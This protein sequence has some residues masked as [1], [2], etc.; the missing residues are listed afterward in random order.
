MGLWSWFF[1]S[2][3]DRVRKAGVYASKQ[4]WAQAR[5]ELMGLEEPEAVALMER[6]E[7]EL[8]K[9][10]L[11]EAVAWGNA[12]DEIRV[13][14]H[15]ELA[16]RF[17]HGQLGEEL[18]QVRRT[19]RELRAERKSEEQRKLEEKQRQLV[20]YAPPEGFPQGPRALDGLLPDDLDPDVADEVAARLGL[21]VEAYPPHLRDQLGALGPVFAQ[22]ILEMD[23]GR[24]EDAYPLLLSLPDTAPLVWWERARAAAA[25][26]HPKD[27]GNAL[28]EFARHAGGHMRIG[29]AHTGVLLAQY[30]AESGEVRTAIRVLRAIAAEGGE[31]GDFFLAQ[32]LEADN[33]LAEADQILTRLA[34]KYPKQ[35]EIHKVLAR[36]RVRGGERRA[37]ILAL[38]AANAQTCDTPG[39][40][41]YTPPDP[42]VLLT[43]ATLYLEEG[44]V[45]RGLELAG[46]LPPSG[47]QTW[48]A[49]YLGALVARAEGRPDAEEI[50]ASVRA[51]TPQVGPQA[52]RL[53]TFLPTGA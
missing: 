39:K 32:L 51:Q 31:E 14:M 29:N 5:D 33:E 34:R 26:G 35:R 2:P 43:L 7:L 37:A 4:K 20:D 8:A 19:L 11:A 16:E 6:V 27:A 40:C 23:E 53:A 30:H 42:E 49:A 47:A 3:A 22:A 24:P 13:Q 41:G 50:A 1:P 17:R 28:R 18:Q 21:V 52:A 38:E 46:E 36:V 48:E 12:G 45:K 15:L 25:L 9:A 44:E 10:N